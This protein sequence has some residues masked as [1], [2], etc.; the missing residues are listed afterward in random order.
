MR[1][2]GNILE[3]NNLSGCEKSIFVLVDILFTGL[4]LA[5]GSDAI[6]KI[7][8]LYNSFMDRNTKRVSERDKELS[9][10]ETELAARER[11]IEE[12]ENRATPLDDTPQQ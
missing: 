12:Q 7:F 4:V 2:L 1:V 11:K 10:K 5:G 9:K 6:N 8:K 3:S